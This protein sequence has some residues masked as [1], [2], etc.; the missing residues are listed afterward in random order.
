MSAEEIS[1]ARE[2]GRLGAEEIYRTD[3]EKR[4][5]GERRFGKEYMMY[6]YPRAYQKPRPFIDRM[7]FWQ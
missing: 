7:L 4:A 1:I 2:K 5:E 6:T 3:P